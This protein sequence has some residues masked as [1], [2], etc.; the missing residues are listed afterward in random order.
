[1][2]GPKDGTSRV[3]RIRLRTMPVGVDLANCGTLTTT[4]PSQFVRRI[5]RS[6]CSTIGP[7]KRA[8]APDGSSVTAEIT[9]PTARRLHAQVDGR[10][11]VIEAL[12]DP[13]A[14]VSVARNL[15]SPSSGRRCTL[16]A[17]Q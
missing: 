4:G 8:P 2:F 10:A 14:G 6:G 5:S 12:V 15:G 16:T 17:S 1:M 7:G 9:G 13:T 3:P 11:Q